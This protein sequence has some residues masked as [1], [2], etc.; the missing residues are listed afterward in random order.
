MARKTRLLMLAALALCSAST[1]LGQ[2]VSFGFVGGTPLTRDF[3]ISRTVYTTSETS[4]DLIAFDWF[5]DTRS[6][7]AGLSVEIDLGKSLSLEG[8]ALHRDLHLQRRN[9]FPNGSSQY[10]GEA[11]P[12]TWEWP[13]LAKYRLPLRGAVR[14]FI[15]AGPS[16]RT[17]HNPVPA[18]PSQFGGTAGTGVEFC[19]GR[20]RISPAIRYTRWQYDGDYPRAATKRDQIEFVTGIGY[21]TSI[22]SWRLGNRKLRLGGVG[23]TPLTGGLREMRQPERL[24]EEQGYMGGLAVELDLNRRLSIEVNGL[25]RP[26]R[27]HSYGAVLDGT[28]ILRP[29]DTAFEFTVVTWQF[30][31]LAKYRLLP[32]SKTRPVLEAGP[33]FRAA[34]NLNGY[35]PSRYGFTAGGGIETNYKAVK[36]SPVLRYTRWAKDPAGTVRSANTAANQ[37]ELLF[38]FTF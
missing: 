1:M 11:T 17:R 30:P 13:I 28:G 2:R 4:K 31:V 35:N 37:V 34:G 16:F 25:Y 20:F 3:P 32:E 21:A 18:E 33:S 14:P 26:L 15:E 22:P 24:D 36:I 38:S 10:L 19:L 27:A 29:D 5:S 6:F 8:N 9:V 12:S 7:L 23:G